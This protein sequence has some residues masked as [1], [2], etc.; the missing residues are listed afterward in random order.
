MLLSLAT[1]RAA[2]DHVHAEQEHASSLLEEVTVTA[3]RTEE[4][5]QRVPISVTAIT[6]DD[7]QRKSVTQAYDLQRITPSMTMTA[8]S[9]GSDSLGVQIRGLRQYDTG[10]TN[11]PAVGIYFGEVAQVRSQGMNS[12]LFDLESVQVLK[13]PQGTLFGRNTIGGAVLFTPR[14]PSHEFEG[15]G[16]LSAGDYDL[17][18]VEAAVNLPMGESAALRVAAKYRH[19]DGYIHN[20][21]LDKYGHAIEARSVRASLLWEPT[22][23]ISTTTIGYFSHTDGT[24]FLMKT[25]YFDPRGVSASLRPAVQPLM[26]DGL[27]LNNTLGF[28][29]VASD[30]DVPTESEAWGIQNITSMELGEVTLKN[31]LGYRDIDDF[32]GSYDSDGTRYDLLTAPSDMTGHQYSEELQ[33]LG[34]AGN[35]DYLVG[36]YY[37]KEEAKDNLRPCAFCAVRPVPLVSVSG[38][39]ARNESYSAFA[40]ANYA[41]DAWSEG[42]SVSA[43][44]RI[45][46]DERHFIVRARNQIVLPNG[47]VGWRCSTSATVT[48]TEDRDACGL[49]LDAKYTEPSWEL[50]LNKQWTPE[51]LTYIAHRHGYRTGGINANTRDLTDPY[52]FKPEKATDVEVGLKT[53]F[54]LG[55]MPTRLNVAAYYTWLKDRQAQIQAPKII[56]GVPTSA[57][58]FQNAPKAH[59]TGTEIELTM[60]P[61]DDLELH[62]GY[63]YIEAKNDKFYDSY[64][65]NG[66]PTQVD[67]SDS[68]FTATPKHQLN[69]SVLYTLPYK[70]VGDMSAELSYYYQAK[71]DS[72]D[73]NTRNCGPDGLYLSCLINDAVMPSYGLWNL[74]AQ[75]ERPFGAGFTLSAYV[76]NLFDK[77]Y[78]AWM[79]A[80][81]TTIGA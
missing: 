20:V 35:L 38:G 8:S 19:Q 61:L 46:R 41:L 69:G 53:Q 39:D 48:L 26:E 18:D 79:A 65:V 34:K 7:I 55:S 15:Y 11:D 44:A 56:N 32:N 37:F 80:P 51:F 24:G 81:M 30:A 60:L 63:S 21:L 66:V 33:L 49:P 64:F 50:S 14:A 75:W 22:D 3:R 2:D 72:Y 16:K 1:A 74:R 25:L 73:I 62:I 68:G 42:L 54:D 59:T 13:G 27:A 29:Q 47:T 4:N 5:I 36:L 12:A 76:T 78:Y 28:H 9:R 43:G 70:E 58:F 45:T 67:V 17:Q 23:S 52:K 31:I 77:D 6:A 57:A 10:I 71:V 40:H